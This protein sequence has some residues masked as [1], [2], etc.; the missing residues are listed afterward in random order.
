M[1]K[2]ARETS[3]KTSKAI[4]AT[5]AVF[6][7]VTSGDAWDTTEGE[8]LGARSRKL[9]EGEC[10]AGT[11]CGDD[12]FEFKDKKTGEMKT[13]TFDLIRCDDG[14]EERITRTAALDKQMPKV[15]RGDRVVLKHFGFIDVGQPAP[16][17]DIRV[18]VVRQGPK[19]KIDSH[20]GKVSKVDNSDVPF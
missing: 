15:N 13:V 19:G 2:K 17:S 4:E 12:Y 8:D 14:R 3:R 9:E 11:Y 16:M 10:I 20:E 6:P 1:T 5:K 18:K 7:R